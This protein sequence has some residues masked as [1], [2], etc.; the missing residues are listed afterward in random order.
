MLVRYNI[1][2]PLILGNIEKRYIETEDS[3]KETIKNIEIRF[4]GEVGVRIEEVLCNA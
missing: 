1:C 4:E 3:I 2:D